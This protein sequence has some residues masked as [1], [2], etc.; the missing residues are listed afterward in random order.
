V[1][2]APFFPFSILRKNGEQ[3]CRS[4]GSREPPTPLIQQQQQEKEKKK[5]KGH[6]CEELFF[7]F[8]DGCKRLV[9]GFC[10]G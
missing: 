9:L 1:S 7:V 6:L 10:F 3:S 2:R 4:A 8:I 5:K